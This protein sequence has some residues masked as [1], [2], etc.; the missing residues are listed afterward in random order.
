MFKSYTKVADNVKATQFNYTNA[1]SLI[2]YLFQQYNCAD[3]L[4]NFDK[5]RSGFRLDFNHDRHGTYGLTI[6]SYT[7]HVNDYVIF[8]DDG[9][10]NIMGNK[11]FNKNYKINS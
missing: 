10:F 6:E 11:E 9:T 8:N 5:E 1:L 2:E 4:L 3:F 7:V